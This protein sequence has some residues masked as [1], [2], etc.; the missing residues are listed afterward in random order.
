[1][2][3]LHFSSP[4]SERLCIFR[5]KKSAWDAGGLAARNTWDGNF[6]DRGY[7]EREMKV[8]RRGLYLHAP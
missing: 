4:W 1:M 8:C 2:P 3:V 7:N 6:S 5:E